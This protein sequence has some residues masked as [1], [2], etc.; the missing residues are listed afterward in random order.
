MAAYHSGEPAVSGR[1]KR[2]LGTAAR[3][4]LSGAAVRV[5]DPAAHLAA[6]QAGFGAHL[7]WYAF[8]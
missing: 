2:A 6:E 4:A 5:Y 1:P 8:F 7:G 3:M